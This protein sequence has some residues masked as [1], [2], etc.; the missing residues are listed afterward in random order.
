[1][2]SCVP[3]NCLRLREIFGEVTVV[4]ECAL[5]AANCPVVI[6]RG[7]VPEYRLHRFI[8][9]QEEELRTQAMPRTAPAAY[10]RG[11]IEKGCETISDQNSASMRARRG[12]SGA[13]TPDESKKCCKSI[14]QDLII[15]SSPLDRVACPHERESRDAPLRRLYWASNEGFKAGVQVP[16]FND[17]SRGMSATPYCPEFVPC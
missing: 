4:P 9:A 7:A 8:K 6:A 17:Y 14:T 15:R 12:R 13:R 2:A 10:R 5:P 1:M 11:F 3:L 16:Q